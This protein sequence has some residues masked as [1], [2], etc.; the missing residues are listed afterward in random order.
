VVRGHRGYFVVS[1]VIAVED[2]TND[3]PYLLAGP[4][5]G[6]IE[7]DVRRSDV[8]RRVHRIRQILDQE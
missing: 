2:R 7:N 3:M 1:E 4:R 8:G 6:R 5:L